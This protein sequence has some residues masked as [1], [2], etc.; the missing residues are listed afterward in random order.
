MHY[1]P[2]SGGWTTTR[3]PKFTLRVPGCQLVSTVNHLE[4]EKIK[5][6]LVVCQRK[7]FFQSSRGFC[8]IGRLWLFS[9]R[10]FG[11]I[12]KDSRII[13]DNSQDAENDD[14]RPNFRGSQ[15][16]FSNGLSYR[17]FSPLSMLVPLSPRI[18]VVPYSSDACHEM[19]TESHSPAVDRY[20]DPFIVSFVLC[21]AAGWYLEP[22]IA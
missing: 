15:A 4:L 3:H 16:R 12:T 20:P 21:Q 17:Y 6:C 19:N 11:Q 18:T 9:P 10:R 1:R 7:L 2:A 14:V 5:A 22:L 13:A 8:N